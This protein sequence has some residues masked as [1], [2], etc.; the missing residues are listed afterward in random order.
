M[1]ALRW[2][3]ATLA[4]GLELVLLAALAFWGFTADDDILVRLA[5]GLGAPAL[6]IVIWAFVLAPNAKRRLPMPWLAITK[7]VLFGLGALALYI[8]NAPGAAVAL[9]VLAV[10]NIALSTVLGEPRDIWARG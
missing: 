6:V 3:N 8:A 7:L 9:A 5:L 1:Q 2:A 10:V 4:F